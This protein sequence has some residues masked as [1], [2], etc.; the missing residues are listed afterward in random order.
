MEG[1]NMNDNAKKMG[2]IVA[3]AALVI[4]LGLGYG[5]GNMGDKTDGG[6]KS[7]SSMTHE[8]V[9]SK[10]STL[11]ADLVALGTEHQDL[12]YA[13]VGDALDG[14]PGAEASKADLIKNG[15]DLSAAVGSVY[16][17]D[18][19]KKFN[20]IWNVH[21]NAF[22]AYAVASK[23]DDA[24]GKQAAMADIDANY[25]KPISALLAGA[26][27][28][29]PQATLE[30][31]FKEHIDMTAQMIDNHVKGDFAAE[32]ELRDDSVDHLKGLMGTLA[33]AIVKQFP[34]KF[35]D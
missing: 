17:A 24:A 33:G 21:L 13:A 35:K 30:A 3:I 29:L 7:S 11:R 15:A 28:N 12:T 10:A 16:G 25:T 4:G 19:Q 27:P 14:S 6:H 34:E 23:S 2:S 1:N 31:G 9:G 32:A 8:A 26:N 22:V 5:L 20:D 18:A